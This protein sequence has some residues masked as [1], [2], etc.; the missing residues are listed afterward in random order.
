MHLEFPCVLSL[1]F[2]FII[3]FFSGGDSRLSATTGFTDSD[4]L[5]NSNTV[6]LVMNNH[7]DGRDFFSIHD[8]FFYPFVLFSFFSL[9]FGDELTKDNEFFQCFF[10]LLYWSISI[11]FSQ[12]S[13]TIQDGRMKKYSQ[14]SINTPTVP[15]TRIKHKPP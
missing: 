5:M 15:I 14:S 11:F 6:S 9:A 4:A 12:G 13:I 8:L 7:R 3:F 10:F 2:I 1:F